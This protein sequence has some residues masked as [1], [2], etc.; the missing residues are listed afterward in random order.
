MPRNPRSPLPQPLFDE[1]VFSQGA[2]TPD[3]TRFK[4][5][6]PSDA[7]LYAKIQALLYEDVVGFP[8]SRAAP[9]DLY[10]LATA[11]GPHGPEVVQAI[12]AAGQ[13]TFH[14]VGDIG[15]STA[16]KYPDEILVSDR[17]TEDCQTAASANRPAFLYLLGDLI[18]DFGEPQY[19]YDQFYEPYRNY[20]API[21]AIPGNHDSFIVPGTTAAET[22]L[23]TF[24]RNFCATEPVVTPEA[25]SLHRTAM[26]QP[27]VYFTLDAPF[28]R[29]I[30]LFSNALEDPGVISS[31]GGVWKS[32]PDYQL[33][34]LAAQLG[35]IKSDGFG[36]AILLAVH[37]PPFSYAPATAGSGA[38]GTHGG[39]PVMLAQIDAV[40]REAGVYPHAFVAGHSHN[41][42]RFTR[43][44]QFGGGAYEIPFIVC[45]DGGHGLSSLVQSHLG[46]PA[47]E[48]SDGL[49]VSY[50][51]SSTTVET[52]RLILDR[53]DDQTY[54]YLRIVV[55]SQQLRVGF[56]PV[57][58]GIP[59][60]TVSDVVTVDLPTH[61]V[62]GAAST[63]V[64]SVRSRKSTGSRSSSREARSP[65]SRRS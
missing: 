34:F 53:H 3:P 57:D 47:Q 38:G 14:M 1:P 39:N 44:L 10:E 12:Q 2:P 62:V 22:P 37:H 48:P 9:G 16:G 64:R 43:S 21:F 45:G 20:P 35:R 32:V 29:I 23:D 13:I 61:T 27:G 18:Y 36:G 58:A 15:A 8:L 6:H 26:T 25:G 4:V 31:E 30:G 46:S 54:G 59:A 5:P 17:I 33:D 63:S 55:D 49:D 56:Y 42:Q 60:D 65:K 50:L 24:Q 7:L 28:V 41:Y 40:C 52:Q 11:L 51:D 19:Y